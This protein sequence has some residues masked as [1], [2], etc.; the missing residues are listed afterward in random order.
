[1]LD[2]L[3]KCHDFLTKPGRI[4][5]FVVIQY[6]VSHYSKIIVKDI[7]YIISLENV[8]FR[9][10]L[11]EAMGMP[12]NF[13]TMLQCMNWFESMCYMLL[14]EHIDLF[15]LNKIKNFK[16]NFEDINTQP[17]FEN[18]NKMQCHPKIENLNIIYKNS[19]F[20][21]Q[22]EI[23][24]N[25]IRD[26]VEKINGDKNELY[27]PKIIEL[28]LNK[29]IA[30]LP[31]WTNIMGVHV[32]KLNKVEE[33]FI[34]KRVSNGPIESH[35]KNLKCLMLDKKEIR[36]DRLVRKNYNYGRSLRKKIIIKYKFFQNKKKKINATASFCKNIPEKIKNRIKSIST[37]K[38]IKNMKEEWNKPKK[39]LK[40]IKAGLFK[41]EHKYLTHIEDGHIT[42]K[43]ISP[44]HDYTIE[45][46]ENI[47][48]P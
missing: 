41:P 38:K 23:I 25:N 17:N 39:G 16:N 3:N 1:M 32:D 22:F 47:P 26:N 6:C 2:Y 37:K 21:K 15:I 46:N 30:F 9:T 29:Y 11:R 44:D 14:S 10:F 31:L 34:P 42:K 33:N 40:K 20:R 8:H 18:I 43:S 28:I 4:L 36:L 35:F 13:T 48:Y 5:N 24:Y 27:N 12:F 19:P 7:D 45:I